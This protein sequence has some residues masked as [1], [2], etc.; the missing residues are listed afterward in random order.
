M[1]E[2][3]ASPCPSSF[4]YNVAVGHPV[5]LINIIHMGVTLFIGQ[6]LYSFEVSLGSWNVHWFSA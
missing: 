1:E 6:W 4:A 2:E 3:F 5:T